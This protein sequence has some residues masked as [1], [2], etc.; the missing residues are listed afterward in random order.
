MDEP[1]TLAP[2]L[3]DD[4]P[5]ARPE[6]G[7]GKRVWAKRLGW[8]L[9]LL[10]APVVLVAGFLSTPIGKRFIVTT[11]A[12]FLLGG[13]LA[14]LMILAGLCWAGYSLLGRGS[15]QPLS[16]TAGNFIRCLPLAVTLIDSRTSIDGTP[17]KGVTFRRAAMPEVPLMSRV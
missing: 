15:S 8:A 14:A 9:A 17:P 16:D 4:S 11:F 10:L 2:E 1:E 13:I 5:P 12:F 6:Q 3:A 7:R